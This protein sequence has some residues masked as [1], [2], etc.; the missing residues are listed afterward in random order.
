MTLTRIQEVELLL[1][2]RP[3]SRTPEYS[4]WR[5]RRT[6]MLYPQK[7]ERMLALKRKTSHG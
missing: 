3:P 2:P 6:R 7:Y 5:Y 4:R 1:G